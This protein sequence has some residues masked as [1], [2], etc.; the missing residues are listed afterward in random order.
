LIR[1]ALIVLCGSATSA[2]LLAL[3][4]RVEWPYVLLGWIALVPWF[5]V[6]DRGRGITNALGGG[7]L[8]TELFVAALFPWIPR[9]ITDYSGAPIVLSVAVTLL[10]APLLQPQF[11]AAAVARHL[12]RYAGGGMLCIAVVGACAYVAADGMLPKLFAD[13]IGQALYASPILRQAADTV[14]AHGLTWLLLLVNAFVLATLRALASSA[15]RGRALWMPLLSA[16]TVPLLLMVYGA[17]RLSQFSA[18]TADGAVAVGI[19]QA[20][21]SHYDRLAADVGTFEAV[22]RILEPHFALSGT[23]LEQHRVDLLVWPETVYPTSF[24]APKS[25]DG[26]GFDRAIGALVAQSGVPLLFG[27]YE[28]DGDDEFNVA[29]LLESTAAAQVG[30]DSYRK[31]TLFPFTEYIPAWIDSP[32]LRARLP[33]TGRW[34]RGDGPRVLDATL[35][36]GRSLRLAPLICYDAIDPGFA[37]TAVRAGAELLTTLSNDSWFAYPGVQRLIL[38]VSAFRSI[39]TRRPQ[40]RATPTGISAVIDTTGAVTDL[41]DVDRRGTIVAS[42]VPTRSAWTPMVAWGNWF[43]AAALVVGLTLLAATAARRRAG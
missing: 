9:A 7:L 19:V 3:F 27:T 12:T 28:R 35:P 11:I 32:R 24:G 26:A 4:A 13:T 16:V 18:A 14:G 42:L 20:N 40:I 37:A 25:A 31:S 1:S 15:P 43:P 6:L 29:V 10:I 33:W 41:I 23:L 8:L 5:A 2:L 17:L 38:I 22:R 36:D 30:F 34:K 21:I 39:E